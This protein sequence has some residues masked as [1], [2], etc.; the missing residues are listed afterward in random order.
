MG[1]S[2][3]F[4]PTKNRGW[5]SAHTRRLAAQVS[6]GRSLTIVLAPNTAFQKVLHPNVHEQK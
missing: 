1:R 5:L 4:R 3:S 6:D 2:R